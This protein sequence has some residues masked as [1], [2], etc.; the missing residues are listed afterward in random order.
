M[1]LKIYSLNNNAE[2]TFPKKIF[3]IIFKFLT[4]IKNAF[5]LYF[6]QVCD[7]L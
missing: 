1:F 6:E 3:K 5:L 2:N 4:E 7:I